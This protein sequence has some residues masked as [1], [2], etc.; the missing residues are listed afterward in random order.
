[1]EI[2]NCLF[3]YPSHRLMLLKLPQTPTETR[4]GSGT[5]VTRTEKGRG[6]TASER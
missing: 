3:V 6:H 1:M 2:M 4:R 5:S